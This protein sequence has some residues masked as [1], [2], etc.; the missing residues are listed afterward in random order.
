VQ[1][2]LLMVTR[3]NNS[4]APR[5]VPAT[6][7]QAPGLPLL[8][9]LPSD[10]STLPARTDQDLKFWKVLPQLFSATPCTFPDCL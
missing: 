3:W 2:R 7:T 8:H 1:P 10:G 6:R 5:T 9:Q 4:I